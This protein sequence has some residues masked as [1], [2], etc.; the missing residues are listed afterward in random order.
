MNT[1]IAITDYLKRTGDTAIH[2]GT[3]LTDRNGFMVYNIE[4]LTKRFVIMHIYGNAQHWLDIANEI[5]RQLGCKKLAG[6]VKDRAR[7][8]L[9][10]GKYGFKLVGYILEREVV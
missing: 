7:K 10:Q 1:A 5:A 9:F 6:G 3:A 4:P 2:P 8:R